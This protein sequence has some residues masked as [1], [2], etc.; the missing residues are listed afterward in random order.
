VQAHAWDFWG[1]GWR[2][3]NSLN[4]GSPINHPTP[5]NTPTFFSRTPWR[6]V[7][8][9]CPNVN[10]V[11]GPGGASPWWNEWRAPHLEQPWPGDNPTL[12]PNADARNYLFNDGS[13][14]FVHYQR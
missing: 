6:Q 14:E 8:A 3:N 7:I 12:S 11:P 4:T 13:V 2:H 1:D 5:Q 9:Y 10:R